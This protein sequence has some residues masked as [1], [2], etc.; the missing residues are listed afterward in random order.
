MLIPI[1]S[2]EIFLQSIRSSLKRSILCS[3]SGRSRRTASD[4]KRHESLLTQLTPTV[5]D[6]PS[7]LRQDAGQSLDLAVLTGVIVDVASIRDAYLGDAAAA[8]GLCKPKGGKKR[9]SADEAPQHD[10]LKSCAFI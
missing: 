8:A 2:K 6:R 1:L 9:K 5:Q 10:C 7:C 3:S 4:Q